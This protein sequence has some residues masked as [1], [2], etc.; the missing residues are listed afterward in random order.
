LHESLCKR[1]GLSER[2]LALAMQK[3]V[4]RVPSSALKEPANQPSMIEIVRRTQRN[5][6]RWSSGEIA[7]RWTAAGMLEAE[8]QFRKIIGHRD[9]ATLIVAIERDRDR[10]RHAGA[11][12]API[13][14]AAIVLA[15]RPSR[16]DRCHRFRRKREILGWLG[17]GSPAKAVALS[18]DAGASRGS[19]FSRRLI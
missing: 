15:S 9:L 12:H 11:A 7:L 16:S 2:S 6:K 4:V 13:E 3:V 1:T 10:R 17:R 8:R 5:V 19:P 18:S 14:E